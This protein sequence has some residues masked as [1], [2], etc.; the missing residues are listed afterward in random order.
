MTYIISA[1]TYWMVQAWI[2]REVREFANDPEG[3]SKPSIT[4]DEAWRRLEHLAG[5]LNVNARAI[6]LD[7][8][9]PHEIARLEA[10][11]KQ[12]FG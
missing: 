11:T 5:D 6:L 8:R 4:P 9:R 3:Y 12:D 1:E 7:G 2:K 10:L